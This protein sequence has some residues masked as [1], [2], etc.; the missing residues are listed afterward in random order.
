MERKIVIGCALPVVM[1]F[2]VA[3]CAG[4]GLHVRDVEAAAVRTPIGSARAE[5]LRSIETESEASGYVLRA[6]DEARGSTPV[7]FDAFKKNTPWLYD[8]LSLQDVWRYPPSVVDTPP[9]YVEAPPAIKEEAHATGFI[10]LFYDQE[11]RF[12]GFASA[13][14]RR[15]ASKER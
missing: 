1:A 5:L 10:F 15:P 11:M 12:I 3:G 13:G 9:A 4:P 7:A 2:A 14:G 6:L 8:A